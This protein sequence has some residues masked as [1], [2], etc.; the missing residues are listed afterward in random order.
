MGNITKIL[1]ALDPLS[2]SETALHTGVTLAE[3]FNA[4][5]E[6]LSVCP[7]IDEWTSALKGIL[8]A[9]E[10][11]D[12]VTERESERVSALVNAHS[13]TV[14][15]VSV[16]AVIGIPFIEVIR[17]AIASKSDLIIQAST[18]EVENRDPFTSADWHLIRKSPIPVWI[19]RPNATL[20]NRIAVAID[21]LN[22]EENAESFN[23]KLLRFAT[24]L[25]DAFSA[26]LSVYSAWQLEG[27][28]MFRNSPF[29]RMDDRK[30]SNLLNMR[31]TSAK[32]AQKSLSDWIETQ[33]AHDAKP[34]SWHVEK[35]T[36]RSGIAD[37][38]NSQSI[39]LAVMGTVGRTG[40]PGYLIGNTAETVL[41]KIRCSV[42]TLKP[43]L[44]VSP[45]V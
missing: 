7:Q 28:S 23:R 37:F 42:V 35:K 3:K 11:R 8:P 25:S 17:R 27:E 10:I 40:I 19:A 36:P 16:A 21:V 12:H 34:I 32:A 2:S 26:E 15:E 5:L 44:F 31:E 1:I 45:V 39:D 20:P 18:S 14:A 41:N 22:G 9:T 24:D 4:K 13:N 30:I 6:I 33:R 43:A 38:I 29:V